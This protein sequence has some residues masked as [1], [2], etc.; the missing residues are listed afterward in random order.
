MKMKLS[1]DPSNVAIVESV[2]AIGLV[3]IGFAAGQGF[4]VTLASSRRKIQV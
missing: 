3:A 1:K 4:W 2:V